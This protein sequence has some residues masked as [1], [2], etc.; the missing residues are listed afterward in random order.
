MIHLEG[1]KM[2]WAEWT[3]FESQL[4]FSDELGLEEV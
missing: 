4:G 2:T 1:V 3:N